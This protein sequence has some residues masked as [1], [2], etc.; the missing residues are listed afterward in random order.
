MTQGGGGDEAPNTHNTTHQQ[1]SGPGASGV[2][3]RRFM[4]KTQ[5]TRCWKPTSDSQHPLPVY[6]LP[7][8]PPPAGLVSP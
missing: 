1:N 8:P 3:G 4:E 5:Q 7:P 2:A 6:P